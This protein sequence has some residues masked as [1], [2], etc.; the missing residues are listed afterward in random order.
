MISTIK[1]L[2]DDFGVSELLVGRQ[3]NPVQGHQFPV[4]E[5]K[6]LGFPLSHADVGFSLR[7]VAQQS[8]GAVVHVHASHAEDEGEEG[9]EDE[10]SH[11]PVLLNVLVAPAVAHPVLVWFGGIEWR[12]EC[13][14][15]TLLGKADFTRAFVFWSGGGISETCHW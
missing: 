9:E 11:G 8:V 13:V 3:D 10:V 6:A 2:D 4:D 14:L 1:R 7:P 5:G 15:E 12:R